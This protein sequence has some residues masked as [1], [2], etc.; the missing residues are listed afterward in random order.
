M[1]LLPHETIFDWA[2]EEKKRISEMNRILRLGALKS[3]DPRIAE[4]EK[5]LILLKNLRLI[6][7]PFLVGVWRLT[8]DNAFVVKSRRQKDLKY[9]EIC[10]KLL[11]L[12]NTKQWFFLWVSLIQSMFERPNSFLVDST[13]YVWQKTMHSLSSLDDRKYLKCKKIFYF[14]AK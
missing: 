11:W 13:R 14:L 9:I 6:Q 10:M 7:C 2:A 12:S 8:K 3:N 1:D 5:I 4:T